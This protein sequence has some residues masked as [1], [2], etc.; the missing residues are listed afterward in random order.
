VASVLGFVM[1]LV[2]S[3]LLGV[4]SR[5]LLGVP[6]GWPRTV[7]VSAVVLTSG[8]TVLSAVSQDLGLLSSNGQILR[9][10]E[11]IV[12]LVLALMLGWTIALGLAVLVVLETLVPTGS[13]GSPVAAV[14]GLRARRRRTS[15]YAAILGIA[16]RNGLGRFLGRG[17]RLDGE[18]RRPHGGPVVASG[19]DRGWRHVREAGPDAGQPPRSRR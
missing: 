12:A 2:N 19:D 8:S 17:S 3:V 5:R 16:V 14:R 10:D 18:R 6:V 4:V 15:R 7:L 1:F 13:L 11:S 9:D